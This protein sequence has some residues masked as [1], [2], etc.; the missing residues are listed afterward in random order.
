VFGQDARGDA[1]SSVAAGIGP[2]SSTRTKRRLLR[3]SEIRP[4]IGSTPRAGSRLERRLLRAFTIDDLRAQAR[5]RVP[6]AVFDYTDGAADDELSLRRARASYTSVTFHPHVLRP[7]ADVDTSTTVAG[8]PAAMPLV[9]APTGF[10]RMM[11]HAG[12]RA[13]SAAAARAGLPYA[14]STLGTTPIEDVVAFAR[15]PEDVWFQLYVWRDRARS[16]ELLSRVRAAGVDVLVVTVDVPVAGRRLRDHRNGLTM[17]PSL[18]A[19][20]LLQMARYPSWWFNV[21]TT[22][23]L[24]FASFDQRAQSLTEIINGTFDASVTIADLDWLRQQW[25]GRIL[26][27]GVQRVDDAVDLARAGVDG[28]VLSNHGGRQLDQAEPPLQLLPRVVDAVDDNVE[29]IVDTGVRSGSDVAAA[30]ALGACAVFVGRAYL[31]GLMAGGE[32][33]V[34]RALAILQS[35]FLR[36]MQLLGAQSVKDLRPDMVTL[37]PAAAQTF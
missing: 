31:Y 28:I 19:R 37:A 14:L 32:Q 34:D 7:V 20:T 21:L 4:L 24:T 33:G 36:T 9:L 17:P 5:Q 18:T 22:E 30:V 35:E 13:V 29:V 26:A 11:H 12:E 25:P 8:R 23:P 2:A 1:T 10:T 6:R 16:E 15:Q 27:K 3:W